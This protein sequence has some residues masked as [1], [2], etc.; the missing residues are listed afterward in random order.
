MRSGEPH[1]RRDA[2]AKLLGLV[3][4]LLAIT[5]VPPGSEWIYGALT[6]VLLVLAIVARA[7]LRMLLGHTL[8]LELF[9]LGVA[10]IALV[11]PH[12]AGLFVR[13][14]ARGSVSALA[15]ALVLATTSKAELLRTIER[16]K[17]PSLLVTTLSLTARY[18]FVLREES[19]RLGR[20]RRAR[21]FTRSRRREWSTGAE[22]IGSL[23]LRS[24]ARAE[25]IYAA[26][27]ARGWKG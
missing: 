10:G 1:A 6:L 25:R 21:S 2:G 19:A 4:L 17:L 22:R 23:F 16:L 20:A 27:T 18:L 9:V 5:L 7:P 24:T 11:Q 26:M 13:L 12:G 8:R 14:L 3:A 15:L